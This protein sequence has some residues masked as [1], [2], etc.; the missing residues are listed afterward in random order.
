MITDRM[1]Q[2]QRQKAARGELYEGF[3]AGYICRQPPLQE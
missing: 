1:L 2:C 3:A